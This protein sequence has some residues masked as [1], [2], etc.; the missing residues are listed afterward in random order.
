MGFVA[1]WRQ[2]GGRQHV[3]VEG[4]WGGGA[5]V[6]SAPGGEMPPLGFWDVVWR[7]GGGA[8]W[9][10]LMV[11]GFDVAVFCPPL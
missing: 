6:L 9:P 8:R 10:I 5:S 7:G 2:E 1:A 4:G 3:C 11:D